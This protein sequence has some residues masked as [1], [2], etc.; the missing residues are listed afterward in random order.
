MPLGKM[1]RYDESISWEGL[2]EGHWRER[3]VRQSRRGSLKK[4]QKNVAAPGSS[5]VESAALEIRWQIQGAVEG[6]WRPSAPESAGIS[7]NIYLIFSTLKL[8]IFRR[9]YFEAEVKKP[10]TS[11]LLLAFCLMRTAIVPTDDDC[12]ATMWRDV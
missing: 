12:S 6:S 5:L 10:R 4:R 1:A 3:Q 7:I 9:F 8:R 2:Q 11:S